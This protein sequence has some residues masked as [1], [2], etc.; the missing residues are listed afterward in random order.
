L[1]KAS[2]DVHRML[3]FVVAAENP[4]VEEERVRVRAASR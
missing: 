4:R 1:E 3:L 2:Q